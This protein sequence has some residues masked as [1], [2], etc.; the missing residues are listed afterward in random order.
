M[1]TKDFKKIEYEHGNIVWTTFP[2][3]CKSCGLCIVGCPMKCLSFDKEQNEYLGM[4]AVH[5]DIEKCIGCGTCE[6]VCPDCAVVVK[7]QK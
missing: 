2:D 1:A 7:G 4:P 3:I 5:C 6:R